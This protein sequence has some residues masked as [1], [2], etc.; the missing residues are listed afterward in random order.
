MDTYERCS[1]SSKYNPVIKKCF[2]KNWFITKETV[3]GKTRVIKLKREHQK[4][5]FYVK[6]G[7]EYKKHEIYV[8]WAEETDKALHEGYWHIMSGNEIESQWI[9]DR[10]SAEKVAVKKIYF[11][12][13]K[14]PNME[15][16]RMVSFEEGQ[17]FPQCRAQDNFY[18]F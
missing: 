18:E 8:Q 13:G 17:R 6:N 5:A 2:K 1:W 15:L 7:K 9:L 16:I 10:E 4:T 12:W 14:K 11:D 3:D